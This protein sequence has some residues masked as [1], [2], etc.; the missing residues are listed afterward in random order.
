LSA[1]NRGFCLVRRLANV[2]TPATP[3]A[4]SPSLSTRR[5]GES[6]A[7]EL[8]FLLTETQARA[9]EELAREQL[10]ADPH[11]DPARDGAYS[12]TS[13]YCDTAQ[14]DVFQRRASFK[15][16]KH[17]L[18]R[19]Q[20]AAW[21]YLERKTKSGDR[22]R[23]QR[24]Q[25]PDNELAMLAD[26][27][28]AP[29]WPGHWFHRHLL[30][31]QLRPVCRIGYDRL[32][33][34][35]AAPQGPLRLTF[36]RGLRGVRTDEWCVEPVVEGAAFLTERVICEFKYRGFLPALFKQIIETLRLTPQ[37]VSKYRTFLSNS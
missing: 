14:L 24:T 33:L 7:Y 30:R 29:E 13:L 31:R 5:A 26:S 8:K 9:V 16:R 22:V 23:K 20:D 2:A 19:Y 10:V 32:A 35:G 15:R 4:L 3:L 28:S 1:R 37:P 17:R 18:R 11:G 36:D 25:V 12:T 21:I 34:V 6:P 27:M